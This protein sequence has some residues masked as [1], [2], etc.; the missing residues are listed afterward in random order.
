MGWD[1]PASAIKFGMRNGAKWLGPTSIEVFVTKWEKGRGG[2]DMQHWGYYRKNKN[3]RR[4]GSLRA[5]MPLRQLASIGT[6]VA[7]QTIRIDT[8]QRALGWC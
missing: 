2:N 7:A 5:R 8:C 3:L 1:E 6:W 4:T